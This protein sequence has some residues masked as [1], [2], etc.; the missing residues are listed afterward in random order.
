VTYGYPA[1]TSRADVVS[2]AVGA[3]IWP[4]SEP[5]SNVGPAPTVVT[6][7]IAANCTIT[8]PLWNGRSPGVAVATVDEQRE[9]RLSALSDNEGRKI[10]E[11]IRRQRPGWLVI[12][13]VYSRQFVAFPLFAISRRTIL[14]ARYPEALIDRMVRAEQERRMRPEQPEQ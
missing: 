14:A 5:S 6:A 10:A 8:T 9:A 4:L 1:V 11:D 12:F 2:G 3:P 7:D 13:G